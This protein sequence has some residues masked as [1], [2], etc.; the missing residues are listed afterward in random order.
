MASNYLRDALG[1]FVKCLPASLAPINAGLPELPIESPPVEF[2]KNYNTY[3]I[4]SQGFEF[5]FMSNQ[6]GTYKQ[7]CTFVYCKDFLHDAVWAA[8][9]KTK[10]SIYSFEYDVAK[11]VPLDMD[12]CVFA[13]RNT[14]Y[15]SK[16]E[17]FHA[18]RAACQEFLNG[19]E[20]QLGFQPSKVY[21]VPHNGAPCWL[22]LGD[23][24]WQIA[25]PMVG[26]FTLFIR[27]GFAHTP[28]ETF[29]ETLQ[30]A[31]SGKIKIGEDASYAGNRDASYIKSA[32]KALEV[33]LEHGVK[34]FHP[35]IEENYPKNLPETCGS[36]HDSLGPVNF[37]KNAQVKKAM[38]FW[39]R[40]DYWK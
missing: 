5:A 28:G 2:G 30:K 7:A 31:K 32:W 33:V 16:P 11:D 10:W 15:K 37:A 3:Q 4:Y 40:E 13:F 8:V 14:A 34:I 6:G 35:T 21:E 25:P 26:F 12:H 39:F 38:P 24:R 20:K 18:S 9:N 27:L 36:L 23:K 17:E 19:I 29:E 1:R 22:V